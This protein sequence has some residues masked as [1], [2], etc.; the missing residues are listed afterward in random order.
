[1]IDILRGLAAGNYHHDDGLRVMQVGELT[2][3]ALGL[4]SEVVQVASVNPPSTVEQ[5]GHVTSWAKPVGVVH[6]WSL[7]NRHGRT[8]DTSDD[9]SYAIHGRGAPAGAALLQRFCSHLPDLVN[10]RL[11]CQEPDSGLDPHE[12]HLPRKIGDRK[13]SMRARFHL[14]IVTNPHAL[15]FTDGEWRH[16]E[17]GKVYVFNNGCV[18][19]ARNAGTTP[20]YHL[21]WDMLMTA[22]AMRVM[23][24]EGNTFIASTRAEVPVVRTETVDDWAKSGGM[25]EAEFESRELVVHP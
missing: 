8:D 10:M 17:E 16:L 21:V 2:D 25:P 13:V 20:R 11:N 9:F 15:V 6:Q 19:A 7:W 23:F 14:P 1:M 24:E 3:D 4:A 5:T 18:H 12:E 22:E